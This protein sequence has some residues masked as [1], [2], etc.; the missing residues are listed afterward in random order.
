M[1]FRRPVIVHEVA[2]AVVHVVPPGAAF[3]VYAVIT[4]PPFLAGA[5]HL[6]AE[7]AFD[8]LAL[9]PVGAPGTVRGVTR[10]DGSDCAERPAAF[11]ASTVNV[12]A[13]PFARPVTV[14]DVPW[15][16]VHVLPPALAVA[17]Y[18]VIGT[19]P[20]AAGTFHFTATE[21]LPAT[22]LTP[23]GEPG[24]VRGV[25]SSDGRDSTE[26]PATFSATVVNA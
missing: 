16:V 19:P 7:E 8:A 21:A 3:T 10:T 23:V 5:T 25:A 17:V 22:A 13:V 20:S 2:P 1:P 15:V 12:Y 4:D 24:T 18:P 14:Q 26:A 11:R 6:T 9:T